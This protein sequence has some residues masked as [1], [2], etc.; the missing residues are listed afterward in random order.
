[1]LKNL[2]QL[3]LNVYSDCLNGFIVLKVP[4]S[5]N[6]SISHRYILPGVAVLCSSSKLWL[7][8]FS[9]HCL[10]QGCHSVQI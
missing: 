9:L 8:L 4:L 3:V 1:M 2:L 5:P 7:I 10:N 6:Q